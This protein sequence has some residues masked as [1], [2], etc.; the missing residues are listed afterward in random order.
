MLSVERYN[1]STWVDISDYVI[2]EGTGKIPFIERNSD[3]SPIASTFDLGISSTF[4][5]AIV[6]GD[7]F[8]FYNDTQ[9]IFAGYADQVI[10]DY[11]RRYYRVQLVND[12][13][14]LDAYKIEYDFLHPI[15]SATGGDTFKLN[16]SETVGSGDT[17]FTANNINLLW[18]L[19]GCFT[20]AGLTLN[21]AD[22]EDELFYTGAI[23][24]TVATP[25]K[26]LC[27]D[28]NA[29]YC[30]GQSVAITH[31]KVDS[32][33]YNDKITLWDFVQ[34]ICRI[35]RFT[36]EITD[37]NTYKISIVNSNYTINDDNKYSYEVTTKYK[38][39]QAGYVGLML[40]DLNI[41]LNGQYSHVRYYFY[42]S[43]MNNVK[44]VKMYYW[45]GVDRWGSGYYYP[46]EDEIQVNWLNNL[47]IMPY[48][49]DSVNSVFTDKMKSPVFA[50]TG[51][52]YFIGTF[53]PYPM[54]QNLID[55]ETKD[56]QTEKITTD[57]NTTVKSVVKNYIDIKNRTSEIEQEVYL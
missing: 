56:I 6:R 21:T 46:V 44:T 26:R 53:F 4:G 27:L 12:L 55:Y 32:D 1:G 19:K 3:W 20:A 39:N 14:K 11:D 15:M 47:F 25:Y 24:N 8:R 40:P 51:L 5:T 29:F 23:V 22:M 9:I 17:A 41:T 54:A 2:S 35:L 10:Y 52:P 30:L 45:P 49:W 48:E 33:F 38:E 28:Y 36:L 50:Y 34:W 37:V 42:T 57:Y 31:E 16:P 18:A 7:R 43:D 13:M